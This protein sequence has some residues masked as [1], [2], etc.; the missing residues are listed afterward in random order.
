MN[1]IEMTKKNSKINKCP[2][3]TY[4]YWFSSSFLCLFLHPPPRRLL[5]VP[6]F[7]TAAQTQQQETQTKLTNPST[8]EDE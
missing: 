2:N 6:V 7:G 4:F 5:H 8:G 1:T 3:Y